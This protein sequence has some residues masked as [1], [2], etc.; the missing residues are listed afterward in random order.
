VDMNRFNGT[1]DDLLALAGQ[2][3]PKT[4]LDKR[5]TALEQRMLALEQKVAGLDDPTPDP[6]LPDE[7]YASCTATGLNV[8]SGPAST[9]PVVGQLVYAQRV[10]VLERQNGWAHI[11][12][13][14]GW[15]NETYLQFV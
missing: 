9:Y 1:P 15:C 7:V 8:R 11:E 6:P 5:L 4:D 14:A 3:I 10:R 12:T 13:P 2:Q